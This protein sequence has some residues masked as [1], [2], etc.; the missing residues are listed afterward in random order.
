[1]KK[2]IIH[3]Y[4]KDS[5]ARWLELSTSNQILSSIRTGLIYM[6]P[7]VI[8]GSFANTILSLPIDAL[9][10]FLHNFCGGMPVRFLSFLLNGTFDIISLGL[11]ISV[12]Y[13]YAQNIEEVIKGPL[14][15]YSLVLAAFSSFFVCQAVEGDIFSLDLADSKGI[16]SAL[17]IT[18][19]SIK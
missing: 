3:K 9:Q 1:M 2:S 8:V 5:L 15:T 13:A 4:P 16:L 14:N 12:S 17:I 18:I 6:I 10:A 7:L 19:A 11:V